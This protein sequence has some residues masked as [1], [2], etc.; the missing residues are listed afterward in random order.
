MSECVQNDDHNQEKEGCVLASP[1]NP[2]LP[3]TPHTTPTFLCS[4]SCSFM[5]WHAFKLT[6]I[7]RGFAVLRPRH[8]YTNTRAHTRAAPLSLVQR[9]ARGELPGRRN[10][11]VARA[12]ERTRWIVRKAPM[13]SRSSPF[14]FWLTFFLSASG[15]SLSEPQRVLR[16]HQSAS[17]LTSFIAL[18]LRFPRK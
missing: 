4:C 10:G 12:A 15:P 2:P 13:T 3:P 5:S 6:S 14:C 18:Q 16:W 9:R 11:W 7:P 1:L 8:E 17:R